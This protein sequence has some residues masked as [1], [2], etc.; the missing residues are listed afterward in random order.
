MHMISF[1]RESALSTF[2]IIDSIKKLSEY[3][4][5]FLVVLKYSNRSY[6]CE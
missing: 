2:V 6:M 3:Y 1:M 4:K 5:L